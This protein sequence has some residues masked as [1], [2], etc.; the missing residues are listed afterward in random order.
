MI[1]Q[2]RFSRRLRSLSVGSFLT[3]AVAAMAASPAL[4][5][6]IDESGMAWGDSSTCVAP[7]LTQPFASLRDSNWY[8]LVPGETPGSLNGAGWSLSGGASIQA[9][10]T[11]AG[12]VIDLPAGS[13]AVSPPMCVSADYPTA[14]TMVRGVVGSQGVQIM[15]A[16][17]GTRTES[18]AQ[19]VGQVHGQG[20]AWT[21]SNTLNIHPGNLPGWQLV[22]FTFV[23]SGKNGDTQL[24]DFYVDPKMH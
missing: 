15:V 18:N 13:Q 1:K 19:A 9:G 7:L 6:R 22:R 20:S 16:Y 11:G 21:L 10:Q 14:R 4:A 2:F 23:P 17:A 12:T 5:N 3:T 24:Y 8:T